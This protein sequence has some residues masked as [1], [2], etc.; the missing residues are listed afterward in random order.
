[1]FPFK[2]VGLQATSFSFLETASVPE[3]A[4]IVSR[5][6]ISHL[7]APGMVRVKSENDI[8]TEDHSCDVD[9]E[10]F[11][12]ETNVTEHTAECSYLCNVTFLKL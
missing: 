8:S 2:S 6:Q 7:T 1:M 5:Q 11:T 3:G 9:N 10:L 4:E 12:E